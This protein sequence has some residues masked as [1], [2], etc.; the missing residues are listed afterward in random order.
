MIDL[1][2]ATDRGTFTYQAQKADGMGQAGGQAQCL[3]QLSSEA[4]LCV[5]WLVSNLS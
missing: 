4:I 3:L 5:I 2:W 1:Q